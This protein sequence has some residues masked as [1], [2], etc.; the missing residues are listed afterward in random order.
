MLP[1]YFSKCIKR[2]RKYAVAKLRTF[3]LVATSFF[4][5]VIFIPGWY[6][7]EVGLFAAHCRLTPVY[8]LCM[9]SKF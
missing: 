1:C 3:D 5:P 8:P 6:A 2:F 9:L 4:T 7:N